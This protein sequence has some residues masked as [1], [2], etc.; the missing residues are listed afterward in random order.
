MVV[1]LKTACTNFFPEGAPEGLE[2]RGRG[3]GDK[4]GTCSGA[5]DTISN[6]ILFC[7][8]F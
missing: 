1:S 8:L 4:G 5:D 3:E 2:V 7:I 6:C